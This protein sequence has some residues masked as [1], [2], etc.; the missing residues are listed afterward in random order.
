MMR[1]V[2][3][4]RGPEGLVLVHGWG[5]DHRVFAPWLPRLTQ[6]WRVTRTDLPGHGGSAPLPADAGLEAWADAVRLAVPEDAIWVGWSL[7]ALPLLA[8]AARGARPRALLLL[9]ATPCFC[10]RDGWPYGLLRE[11]LDAMIG[12]LAEDARRTLRG[13]H[14][15]LGRA[16]AGDREALR[17]WRRRGPGPATALEPGLSLLR[18]TDLRGRLAAIDRPTTW[19]AGGRDP[20]VPDGAAKE[21]ARAMPRARMAYH[22]E[23]GHLP[24]LTHPEWVAGHLH[25]LS[26]QC[27]P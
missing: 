7:G 11:E 10:Q 4:G 12:G 6:R 3:E 19:L 26:Q 14:A 2:T 21:A 9:A 8:A 18:D 17:P 1:A 15:L 24:F 16:G 27:R 22:P 20:L 23:A 13:F 5:F 25:L